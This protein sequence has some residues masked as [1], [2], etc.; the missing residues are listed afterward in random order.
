MINHP[1]F[2]PPTDN[3]FLFNQKGAPVGGAGAIDLTTTTSRQLQLAIKVI[4]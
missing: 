1:N 2:S 3:E 4:F